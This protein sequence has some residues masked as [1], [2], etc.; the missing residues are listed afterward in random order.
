MKQIAC[1]YAQQASNKCQVLVL[2]RMNERHRILLC[3]LYKMN[4]R[5]EKSCLFVPALA[6]MNVEF[7][8]ASRKLENRNITEV[9]ADRM[10]YLLIK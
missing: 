1:N 10:D 8:A 6:Q 2:C 3:H 4:V 9:S 5:N 7:R